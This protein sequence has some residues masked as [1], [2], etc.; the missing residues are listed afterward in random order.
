MQPQAKDLTKRNGKK[1]TGLF[2][3]IKDAIAQN[4]MGMR[5]RQVKNSVTPEEYAAVRCLRA[6]I[7][8]V[9]DAELEAQSIL[10]S[11]LS[12]HPP[13]FVYG[14]SHVSLAKY[15]FPITPAWIT[16]RAILVRVQVLN[17]PCP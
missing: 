9:G 15:L 13:A 1:D 17:L 5:E 16:D 4:V 3:H 2:D 10:P 6:E 14:G 7:F 11:V 12:P 8:T